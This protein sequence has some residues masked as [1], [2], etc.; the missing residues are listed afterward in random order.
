[1]ILVSNII[2][3][4]VFAFQK[5]VINIQEIMQKDIPQLHYV[6]VLVTRY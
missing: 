4:S 5:K 6:T 2:C 1:M 3:Q